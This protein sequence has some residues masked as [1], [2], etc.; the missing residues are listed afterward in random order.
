MASRAAEVG[1][2]AVERSARPG[3]GGGGGGRWT[4]AG[5]GR[6]TIEQPAG[7]LQPTRPAPGVYPVGATG[8]SG[9]SDLYAPTFVWEKDGRV[10]AISSP[11][12][13]D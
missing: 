8:S 11:A 12:G 2:R 7:I 10:A 6:R 5:G 3:G 1:Q 4:A 13:S 9:A